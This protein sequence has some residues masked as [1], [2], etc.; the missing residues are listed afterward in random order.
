MAEHAAIVGAGV[1]GR[2]LALRLARAGWRVTLWD[3]GDRAGHGSCTWTGAGMLSP[4]C[5]LESRHLLIHQLGLASVAEWPSL[6]ASLVVPVFHQF[7]GSLIVAHGQDRG[8]LRRLQ[9]T[10]TDFLPGT[11]ALQTV[12]GPQIADLEPELAGRFTDG[13]YVPDEGQVDNRALLS[14]LAATLETLDVHW[15][16]G[17]TVTAIRP[18]EIDVHG[19]THR[20]DIVC[21]CRGLA[22]AGDL[23]GV[24]GELLRLHA[25]DVTLSRPVRVMH[26]RY[27]LY[28]VPRADHMYVVGATQIESDDPGPITVRSTLELLSAAY[29]LH[30]GFAEATVIETDTGCRPAYPD[31]LPRLS[32]QPGLLRLNGLYRHGFL[33]S[34]ALT[35][36]ATALI[37]GTP[38]AP[39][40]QPCVRLILDP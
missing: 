4:Y 15:H 26:P 2:L 35:A 5:E 23:R 10:I 37:T 30:S 11:H 28:V 36:A 7:A 40:A 14:G 19:D 17:T 25:P 3:R 9:R 13:L 34:P 16:T 31:N 24:R 32:H 18:H 33:I 39:E 1:A 27:P 8:E 6:L 38:I 22:A 21:D 29:A 20:Y 12:N